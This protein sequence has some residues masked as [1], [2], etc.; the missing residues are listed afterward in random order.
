MFNTRLLFMILQNRSSHLTFLSSDAH[1]DFLNPFESTIQ[2][3]YQSTNGPSNCKMVQAQDEDSRGTHLWL[4]FIRTISFF[5][6]KSRY[7]LKHI[8]L[9]KNQFFFSRF[10]YVIVSCDF[11]SSFI[12]RIGNNAFL[13]LQYFFSHSVSTKPDIVVV[14]PALACSY[15]GSVIP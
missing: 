15:L 6:I 3:K 13:F 1:F 14:F 8:F 12:C 9:W 7:H 10:K 11:L 5:F 4:L 2:T